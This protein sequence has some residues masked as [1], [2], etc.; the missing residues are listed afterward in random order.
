MVE[1][2]KSLV[3]LQSFCKTSLVLVFFWAKWYEPS[4]EGG[5]LYD[6]INGLSEKYKT[7]KFVTVEAEVSPEISE[8]FSVQMVPSFVAL[9]GNEIIGKVEGANPQEVVQLVKKLTTSNKH[10]GAAAAS[11]T[12]GGYNL[13]LKLEQLT[14]SSPV[15]LFMKG[16]PATPKCGFSRQIVEILN[17]NEIKFSTFDILTDNEVREG[18]KLYS[19]WPT[20]PQLYVSGE[21]VGGL[22]IVKE[23]AASANG[24]QDALGVNNVNIPHIPS[25]IPVAPTTAEEPLEDRLKRLISQDKVML[26]M[27]GSPATP[28]CGF[29]KQIVEILN[30][31]NIPYSTFDILTDNEV[32]EGLKVYSEWPT[33]PQL[34]AHGELVGGLDIVKEMAEGTQSLIEQLNV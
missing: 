1:P 12:K 19:E 14:H 4:R 13:K 17:E 8:A 3:D 22:D 24:L 33:Y 2:V 5:P 21:F 18:L 9:S 29:S 16:S 7:V 27:K 26:F 25:S 34:Y 10:V 15:M 28:K 20:Y 11:S 30:N 32:R 23:M 31:N 6:I